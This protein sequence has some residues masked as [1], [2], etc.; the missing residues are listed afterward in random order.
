LND[1][2]AFMLA[3][4]LLEAGR[5]PDPAALADPATDLRSLL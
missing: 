5:S 1:P 3:K 2:R 4:R